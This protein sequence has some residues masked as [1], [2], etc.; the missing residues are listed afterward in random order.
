M[1]TG[2]SYS[3]REGPSVV[4]VQAHISALHS[5]EDVSKRASVIRRSKYRYNRR[6]RDSA[7]YLDG[8]EG[9]HVAM[10]R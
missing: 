10:H 8:D 1:G 2:Q 7:D 6:Y 3:P 4:R 9:S 5:M